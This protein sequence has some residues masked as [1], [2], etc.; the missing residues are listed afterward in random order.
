L[1]VPTYSKVLNTINTIG[2]EYVA[3]SI[4]A[5]NVFNATPALQKFRSKQKTFAGGLLIEEPLEYAINPNRGSYSGSDTFSAAVHE[6]AT[7]A[8]FGVKDTYVS[9]TLLGDDID[10]CKGP[11]A[12]VDLVRAALRNAEKTMTYELT[13]QLFTAGTGNDSKDITGLK[14]VCDDGILCA[15]A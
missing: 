9:V 4:L 8:Q 2:A 14:A 6:F 11:D 5:D 3:S 10:K 1:A 7:K 13:T 15:V 12:L